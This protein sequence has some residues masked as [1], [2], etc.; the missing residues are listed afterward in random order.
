M[1]RLMIGF[2]ALLLMWGCEPGG[3]SLDPGDDDVAAD[4]DNADD[5]DNADDDDTGDD[6]TGDDDTG[7]DD[8]GDDDTGDDD[9]GDDDTG[10]DDDDTGDDDDTFSGSVTL[11]PSLVFGDVGV[12]CT[13]QLQMEIANGTPETVEVISGSVDTGDYSITI[14]GGWGVTLQPG[15][16]DTL[17]VMFEPEALGAQ[18]ASIEVNTNH[19]SYPLLTQP[20]TGTGVSGGQGGDQYTQ[21]INEEVDIVWVIDN[22][23]S[24][25]DDQAYLASNATDLL[26]YLT[27]NG[28]DYQM[29]V[30]TTDTG[31][32]QGYGIMDP[33]TPN[34]A[35]ELASTVQVG[36]NGS[37][38]EQPFLYGYEA[39]TSPLTDP[40]GSNEGLVRPNAG[41]ALI[42][43]TDEEDGSPGNPA[44]WVSNYQALKAD[45]SRVIV[46]GIYGGS[47]GCPGAMAAPDIASVISGT[48]G[49]DVS[50]CDVDWLPVLSQIPAL[51][52]GLSDTF[53]LSG[54]PIDGTID[55][56]VDGIQA[57]TG[58]LYDPVLNAIVFDPNSIPAENAVIDIQYELMVC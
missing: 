48:N 57:Q 3:A 58:W 47:N 23:C 20:T 31:A 4:D 1:F 55:V 5:E 25:M 6:D 39:V 45:P 43:L 30:V 2:C 41:L 29:G 53:V 46:N 44:T 42:V 11:T 17:D 37:G 35:T 26:D 18:P 24:M 7:D 52:T 54:V 28:V 32:L 51:V 9:T 14:N 40:G 12:G 15:A 34:V 36:T 49:V 19:P 27:V 10:D 8:T 22:S 13:A 21:A 38:M 33:S 50:I 56:Y 16:M